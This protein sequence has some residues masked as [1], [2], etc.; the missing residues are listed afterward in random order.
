MKCPYRCKEKSYNEACL[1]SSLCLKNTTNG[2]LTLKRDHAYYYQVQ[3]QMKLCQTE[4]CDFVV[5]RPHDMVALR[6]VPDEHF[7]VSAIVKAML[8]FKA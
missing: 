5:W 6:I 7:I 1:D 3:L 8:F 4:Y 2:D